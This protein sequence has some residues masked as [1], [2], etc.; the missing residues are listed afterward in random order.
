MFLIDEI[1]LVVVVVVY[2]LNLIKILF[3]I[4]FVMIFFTHSSINQV[5]RKVSSF[6]IVKE[7]ML[8]K[9]HV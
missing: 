9:D 2:F 6:I 7:R 8:M 3:F 5:F 1:M 4:T